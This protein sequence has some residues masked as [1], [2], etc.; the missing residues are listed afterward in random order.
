VAIVASGALR[1]DGPVS[2]VGALY[3]ASIVIGTPGANVQGA[4]FTE[5]GYAGPSAAA[6]HLDPG[7]LAALGHQT[8]SFVRVAGSWH[9]F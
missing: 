7:V 6:F 1:L 5:G 9:D 8:G 2:V 4:A 3:A